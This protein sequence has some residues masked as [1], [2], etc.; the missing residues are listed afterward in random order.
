[1]KIRR[2]NSAWLL[3][4]SLVLAGCAGTPKNNY[5]VLTAAEGKTPDGQTPALGIGPIRIAEYL[6]RNGLVYQ[7]NGNRLQIA[8]FEHW[9]ES[10]E[11]G[12]TRVVSLN[13]A[14]LLNT[15]NV[16]LFPWNPDRDPAYGV[17]INVLALD[18]DEQTARLEAEW[19]VHRPQSGETVHRRLSRFSHSSP[20][21]LLS[22]PDLPAAYSGLLLQLSEEIAATISADIGS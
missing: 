11:E 6:N 8:Q 19:L 13:L 10:L 12:V 14:Q 17:T 1:M 3:A 5:Y 21:G 9:A 22:P 2:L 20:G 15:Q 4:L 7:R 18:A 16:R